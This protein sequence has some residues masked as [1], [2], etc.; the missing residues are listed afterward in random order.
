ML[1]TVTQIVQ[2]EVIQTNLVYFILLMFFHLHGEKLSVSFQGQ[3]GTIY[4]H[5]V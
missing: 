2:N 3:K 5:L 4:E 1:L